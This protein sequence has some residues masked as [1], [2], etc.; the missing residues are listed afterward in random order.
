M[1]LEKN[2]R[3]KFDRIDGGW[4][5]R[6]VRHPSTNTLG[7]RC[8]RWYGIHEVYYDKNGKETSMTVDPVLFIHE[9]DEGELTQRE[10]DEVRE[11]GLKVL[12]KIKEG[13]QKDILD[14]SDF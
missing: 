3:T 2:K 12:E 7:V 4:N 6:L 10:V 1:S 14:Y 5:Y 13:M 11:M 9:G 8:N